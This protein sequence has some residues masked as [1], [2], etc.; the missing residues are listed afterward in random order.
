MIKAI[1][2]D[3]DGTLIQT[4][5]LKARS[6]AEAIHLLTNEVVSVQRVMESFKDYVGLSRMEVVAGVAKEYN[7]ELEKHFGEGDLKAMRQWVLDKRLSRYRNILDDESLLRE[8]FCPFNLGLL[9]KLHQDKYKLVLATMS[10]LTE[11]SKILNIMGI[12]DKLDAI[13]TRD[14]VEQG[15]PDPEIYIK[16]KSILKVS[17]DECLVIEDSVNGIKAALNAG[18]R[19]FAVTNN[20]TRKSVHESNLLPDTH[21]IDDLTDLE[22]R[23]Y[24]FIS[25]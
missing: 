24:R 21:I 18:M 11:A 15:K 22:S 10:H 9:N 6:Y 25:K 14:D 16:A 20:I 4:E 5:V 1:I 8:H 13:L 17:S 3:L 12:E 2:F 23:V 7:T 19:V